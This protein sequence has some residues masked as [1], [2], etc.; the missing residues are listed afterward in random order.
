MMLNQRKNILLVNDD[1]VRSKG[2]LHLR[3]YLI[4]QGHRVFAIVPDREKSCVAHAMTFSKEMRLNKVDED[5]FTLAGTPVDCVIVGLELLKDVFTPDIIISGVNNSQNIG[6][7]IFSSGT[8]AAAREGAFN[9]IKSIAIS[10]DLIER[11]EEGSCAIYYEHSYRVLNSILLSQS[12]IE[13]PAQSFMNVNIPK[14]LTGEIV[15]TTLSRESFLTRNV[16]VLKDGG[17]AKIF[18]SG[19]DTSKGSEGED[20]TALRDGNISLSFLNIYYQPICLKSS[21]LTVNY[22]NTHMKGS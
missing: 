10:I 11:H 17:L 20:I 7:E 9:D 21:H 12:E 3:D 5:F 4:A 1:G 22:I 6:R 14:S 2:F 19:Q 15:M 18:V 16:S 8:V 13:W